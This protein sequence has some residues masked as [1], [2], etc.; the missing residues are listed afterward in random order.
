[1]GKGKHLLGA[2]LNRRYSG[3]EIICDYRAD[4]LTNP[5]TGG[6]FMV[7]FFL[8]HIKTGFHFLSHYYPPKELVDII[9]MK[10][11]VFKKNGCTFKV[12][13]PHVL[14]KILKQSSCHEQHLWTLVNNYCA[15]CPSKT[16]VKKSK[17]KIKKGNLDSFNGVRSNWNK[18]KDI[19]KRY[20]DLQEQE[21]QFNLAKMASRQ[22]CT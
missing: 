20:V 22:S 21:R 13:Q 12:V 2:V 3:E 7:H 11:K 5:K 9:V 18:T 10:K 17:K 6:K 15:A 19:V 14:K 16:E 8:P 4:W 1:M